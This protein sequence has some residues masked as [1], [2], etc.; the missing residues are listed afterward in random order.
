MLDASTY[1]I[2]T[3]EWKQVADDYAR[4][5]AEALRLY[6][7]M[8]PEYRD[9]YRQLVLFPVQAMSNL[10]EMYYSQAM[11]RYLYAQGDPEADRYADNVERCFTRD[12][13]LCR[14]Y[15]EDI[16]GGKWRGMM[17]QKHIGYTSWNDQ[18]P[19]RH[20]PRSEAHRR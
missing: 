16:A 5:E 17:T 11:N 12:A 13:E 9:A 7:D 8:E 1:N 20:P 3:G 6:L 14:Q 2:A 4:L 19:R 18:F 10:Y 15:N